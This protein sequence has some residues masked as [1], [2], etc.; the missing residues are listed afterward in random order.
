V[1]G[2]PEE[3]ARLVRERDRARRAGDFAEADGL[4][5]RIEAAGFR[6][7][8]T[9]GGPELH[10][11]GAEGAGAAGLD[12]VP[13]EEVES[14][15][16]EPARFDASVNWLVQGW[17][18]D[19]VRGVGSFLR[20]QGGHTVQHVVVDVTGTGPG[21]WPEEAELISLAEDPGW[22]AARNAGLRRA[23]GAVVVVAD[24]SVEATG[25]VLSPLIDAVHDPGV[26]LAGPFG[27]VTEDLR[28]FHETAGPECDA[29][30]AYLMAFPRR[31]LE[32]GLRFDPKFRFYRSAD[33]EFSFQVLS[34]GLRAVV[35]PAPVTRHEHRL[36]AGTPEDQRRRLSKRNFYRFLDRWRGRFD[37]TVA[38]RAGRPEPAG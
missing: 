38:A 27:I 15:L 17:P 7:V 33:I 9:P 8:D 13:P 6:L 12:A 10:P 20:H 11:A 36:W 26:G 2:P 4:R 19:V 31:L 37:L 32:D 29:V 21:T 24:G 25:D 3:I 14:V 16:A 5:A 34:R 30:E 1:T 23:A 22:A 18:E 28:T 35:S